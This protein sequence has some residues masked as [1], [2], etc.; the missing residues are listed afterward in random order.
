[1]SLEAYPAGGYVEGLQQDLAAAR[2]QIEVLKAQSETRAKRCYE[3]EQER[4]ALCEGNKKAGEYWQKKY[5]E[6]EQRVI[7]LEGENAELEQACNRG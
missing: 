5:A 4:I 2:E 6:L 3:L 7:E 1:M